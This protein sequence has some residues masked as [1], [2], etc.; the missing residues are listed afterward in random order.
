MI[1]HVTKIET[2]MHENQIN[3][4]ACYKSRD[5]INRVSTFITMRIVDYSIDVRRSLLF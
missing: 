5:A 1:S 3:D 4:H 2:R